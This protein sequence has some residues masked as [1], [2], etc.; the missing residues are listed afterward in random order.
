LEFLINIEI[1]LKRCAFLDNQSNNVWE[2]N[3]INHYKL[4]I[5]ED[6]SYNED[7]QNIILNMWCLYPA[8]AFRNL[9]E[10][11]V[12]NVL[13]TSGTLSPFKSFESEL[14]AKFDIRLNN[15]HII[16]N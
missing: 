13:L 11:G 8:I 16:G 7:D 9:L 12:R 5:Q 10:K 2:K 4:Y 6:D 14:D 3:D 1:L 15:S